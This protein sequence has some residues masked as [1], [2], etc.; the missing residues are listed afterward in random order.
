MPRLERKKTT[1]TIAKNQQL[2]LK[3]KKNLIGAQTMVHAPVV[4]YIL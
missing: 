4:F 1:E 2:T 3:S